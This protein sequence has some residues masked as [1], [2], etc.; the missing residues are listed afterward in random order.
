MHDDLLALLREGG[1]VAGLLGG[2]VDVDVHEVRNH[3][4]P[5]GGNVEVPNRLVT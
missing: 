5:F 4:D 3:F 1:A 2:I